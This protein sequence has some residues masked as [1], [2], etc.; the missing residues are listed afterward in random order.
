MPS[1]PS[2]PQE[3]V[4]A[5]LIEAGHRC[6]V[7][8]TSCPLEKAH[9]VPWC[10]KKS[11]EKENLICLCANCH[12]RADREKWG[13]KTLQEYKQNPW[14]MRQNNAPLQINATKRI[15]LTIDMEFVDFDG[16]QENIL[17]HA[18]A[19]LL[20]ISPQAIRV[21]S[22]EKGSVKITLDLP[23]AAAK[24][25]LRM[26]K[27][28]SPELKESLSMFNVIDIQEPRREAVEM[29]VGMVAARQGKL[30]VAA[31]DGR[32][33]TRVVTPDAML[34]EAIP[35]VRQI[36]GRY[37]IPAQDG[38]DLF[39][40]A[41]IAT[42]QKWDQIKNPEAWFLA[43]LRNRCVVYWRKRRNHLYTSVD[44]AILEL[45]AVPVTSPQ[46][47]SE[48][49]RDLN[50]LLEE[51]PPRCRKLL[52][53]RYGL[54]HDSPEAAEQMGDQPATLRKVARR[55]MAALTHVM[56]RR[57]FSKLILSPE[58]GDDGES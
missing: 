46:E 25:L 32:A 44:T 48:L 38:D 5:V 24:E 30:A 27:E 37:Q 40:E 53:L 19:G 4:R 50:S 31:G 58:D 22:K 33:V 47:R 52:R 29:A 11:H 28:N 49:L 41:L 10:E 20:K 3:V 21:R 57:G 12:E 34:A 35:K 45:L 54:G 39:Q 7:C 17:K 51:L 18:I 55:C 16:N 36:L 26:F 9:I 56:T 23:E 2:I 8:G 15:V 1:R 13:K 14:V 42:V 6:A 43:T